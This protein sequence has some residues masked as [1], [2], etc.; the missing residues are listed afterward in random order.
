MYFDSSKC[1]ESNVESTKSGRSAGAALSA[2]GVEIEAGDMTVSPLLLKG[3]PLPSLTSKIL[4]SCL[5]DSLLKSTVDSRTDLAEFRLIANS[6]VPAALTATGLAAATLFFRSSGFE[7][8]FTDTRGSVGVVSSAGG[9]RDKES[10]FVASPSLPQSLNTPSKFR[11]Q[12]RFGS[13]NE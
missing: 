11:W 13:W 10:D 6:H 4:W 3:M 8:L 2:D 1:S 12:C 9:A 5:S 7:G